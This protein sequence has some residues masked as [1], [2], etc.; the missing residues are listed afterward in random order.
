MA[1]YFG[2]PLSACAALLLAMVSS[3]FAA[4]AQDL[5]ITIPL[6]SK[7]TTVQRLN[8]D[9]V[10]ELKKNRIE[11]AQAL[12]Y[13]A[14]LYDPGDP[15]TLNNLGYA[16]ELSGDAERALRYYKLAGEQSCDAVIDVSTLKT[17]KGQPMQ[18]ALSGL[19]DSPM[20]LNRLNVE[21]IT[22]LIQDRGFEAEHLLQ[23]A[24]AMDPNNPFTLNNLGVAQEAE[25]DFAGAV[26]SYNRAATLQSRERIVVSPSARADFLEAYSLNPASAFSLNNLGYLAE[27][28][29]DLETAQLFYS[30]A[31]LA[32]NADAR[33][34]L[35]SAGEAQGQNLVAV[36]KGSD[37]KVA[38]AL[39]RYAD[40]RHL[41]TGTPTLVP[42][43]ADSLAPAQPAKPTQPENVS[44]DAE[45]APQ[46]D[47]QPAP[48]NSPSPNAAPQPNL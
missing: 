39:Q 29:G 43:G 37:G 14:Y 20:Q 30:R 15:F 1:R 34:G 5:R 45:T 4:H 16:A 48:A 42:R 19:K 10:S 40:K 47:A 44:P 8:R 9:G 7:L 12:F 26:S 36:A 21:A 17:L 13:K 33:I 25:G 24:L 31:L 46:P 22:L 3:S 23:R 6:P 2:S 11:A 18:F 41:Q 35:A 27:K 32:P 38:D 28:G